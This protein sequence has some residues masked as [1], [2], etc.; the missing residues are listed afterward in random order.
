GT[1]RT[2]DVLALGEHRLRVRGIESWARPVEA[3]SGA[4]RGARYLGGRTPADLRRGSVLVTPDAWHHTDVVDVQLSED[5]LPPDRPTLHVGATSMT[6]HARPLAPGL[7]RL[8]LPTALPL[9]I[10]DRALL[11][12]PGSR[13]I[14][15]LRV[16]DPVPP[17]LRRRGAATARARDLAGA[18]GTVAAEVRRRGVVQRSVLRRIGVPVE[19]MPDGVLATGDWLVDAELAVSLRRRL[20]ERAEATMSSVDPGLPLAS[21]ARELRLP[22]E[23]IVAAL[24]DPPLRVQGARLLAGSAATV[25]APIARAWAQVR[26]DLEV[27]PFQAPDA[28]RLADLGLDKRAL[29]ALERAGELLRV[30]AAIV[31]LPGA[32]AEAARRLAGLPQPFTTS[33]ARQALGTTRRVALPL[34]G[35]LDRRGLTRRLPDDTRTVAG[36]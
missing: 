31:L 10:G 18:D 12:D 20:R 14:W 1:V 30:E 28:H 19:A 15:G 21:A 29:A 27:D 22:A 24:A 7:A 13:R 23:E 32:D 9:R 16:L 35:H 2:G 6:V 34:L 11:R 5:E 4:A 25:P 17:P 8:V 33:Q 3:V 26:A 36:G